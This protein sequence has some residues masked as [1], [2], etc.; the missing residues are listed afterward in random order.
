MR[1]MQADLCTT[2]PQA[3]KASMKPVN[4]MLLL[5]ACSYTVPTL[6]QATKQTLPSEFRQDLIY[7]TPRLADGT[8]VRFYTD[9]GGGF[10]AIS[11][12]IVAKQ[13][14]PTQQ[15]QDGDR[16]FD[17]VSF[18]ALDPKA[19][20][21]LPSG[22]TDLVST[23]LDSVEPGVGGFLGNRWF[24]GKILEFDYL[25]KSLSILKDWRPTAKQQQHRAQLSF[26]AVP[27]FNWPRIRIEVDGK[28]LEMLFDTGAAIRLTGD[29]LAE[30]KLPLGT[31][32]GGSFITKTRFNEWVA[33]HPEWKVIPVGDQSG[34]QAVPLIRVP[35][36]RIAGWTVGPVWF[37]QRA[38]TNFIDYMSQMMDQPIE[39]AIGG[40]ALKYFKI[41]ADYP[42][43][44]A[45]FSRR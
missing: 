29:A 18:P 7:V 28:P 10:N 6:A 11:K 9:S 40:S 20:I 2:H 37:A 14:W 34:D 45:Y 25:G 16:K 44:A 30:F 39:G 31:T 15:I 23:D 8:K 22:V 4:T 38:D 5:I 42:G 36:V 35:E 41:V 1:P 32:I 26:K 21:P 12:S 3:S 33:N 24:G 43:G 17:T 27:N 13:N 19:S